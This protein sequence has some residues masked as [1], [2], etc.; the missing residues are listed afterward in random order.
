MKFSFISFIFLFSTHLFA[1]GYCFSNFSNDSRLKP[2]NQIVFQENLGQISDQSKNPRPD[3]LFYGT[4]GQLAFHLKK[5]G[6]CYQQSRVDSW[7]EE[8]NPVTNK[9]SK[10]P[11]QT[12]VY[13]VDVNWLNANKNVVAKKINPLN[14]YNNYYLEVCPNGVTGVKSYHEIL[15]ENIYNGIDLKWYSKNGKLKYDYI[16]SAGGD[17]KQIQLE[18]NGAEKISINKNGEL[19]IN[20]PLGKIIEQ[21]PYV[22]QNGKKLNAQWQIQNNVASFNI[23]NVNS[24]LPFII[25]P[26]VRVWGTYYGGVGSGE[27]GAATS[28]DALGNVFIAGYTDSNNGTSIATVGSHQ[29][30]YSGGVNDA[31]L[32]KFDSSGVRQWG[33][34]YGGAIRD[35]ASCCATDAAGNCFMGGYSLGSAPNVIATS[36][37]HQNTNGGGWDGFLVKFNSAGI[38]QWATFY[39]GSGTEFAQSC[40][41]DLAGNAYLSGKSDS[42]FGTVIATAGSHQSNNGGNMDAFLVKFNSSGVRQWGTYYGGAGVDVGFGCCTDANN[43][44]YLTGSTDCTIANVIS[45]SGSHQVA[46]GG[47]A[48]DA[49]LVKFNSSGVRQWGTYYGGNG[50][51][52]GYN[53]V[54]DINLDV[55]LVGKTE[56]TN[57]QSIA[58]IGGHQ[59]AYAGGPFDAFLVKFNSGGVRQWGTY[60]GGAGDETAYCCSVHASGDIYIAGHTSSNAPN[61]A[62][63]TLNAHQN[64][65]G[66]GLT[67]GFIAQFTNAGARQW[68]SFYGDSGDDFIYGCS[69]DAFYNLYFAGATDTNNGFGIATFFGHQSVFGGGAADGYLVRFYDCITPADPLNTTSANNLIGCV[70]NSNTLTASGSGTLTWY[71]SPTATTSIATGTTYVTP[72]LS[73]GV[74]TYYIES[75]TCAL[76]ANRTPITVTVNAIP[77]LTLNSVTASSAICAGQ[78]ATLI[79]SGAVTYTWSTGLNSNVAVVFPTATTVYTAT[80]T[81]T[82]GC[83][84]TNTISISVQPSAPVSLT[85]PYY[86]SCLVIFGGTPIPLAGNPS[87]GVYSGFNVN[88][89]FFI[90]Q[91]IGSFT[92]VYT[93]TDS[94]TGCISSD[95]ITIFVASCL[96]VAENNSNLNNS[97]LKIYPNP[98]S[99]LCNIVSETDLEINIVNQLGQII[100]SASLN[101]SNNHQFTFSNLANGIYFV[102]NKNTLQKINK[103][104]VVIN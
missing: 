88:N 55:Y 45:S 75:E 14:D 70:G 82:F 101:E 43:N 32:A 39:G 90:P 57:G 31:Y 49:F 83:T 74:Y 79:A 102:Q 42:N 27:I 11:N 73:A 16:I 38:R 80:G 94:T 18:F 51:E 25:D 33:T 96:G 36:S 19:I 89:G 95:S 4:D 46:H 77:S 86:N 99:G 44:V 29:S 87:G 68:G 22:T 84:G 20:T 76:S 7:K 3:V 93:Y 12:T 65:Y 64:G 62:I 28:N 63:A 15:Y 2:T 21:A 53:C 85:A 56:S 23:E 41:T 54:S 5:D 59:V 58:T 9:K 100:L 71:P 66:G 26:G 6:I 35:A 81:N 8:I 13:R 52:I 103:K 50:N 1:N 40:A 69:T 37:G 60:Y 30:V 104:I 97:L 34:Y 47:F 67:D 98:T 91:A 61:T 92:P 17:F 48:E 24:S 10:V 72:I 78:A